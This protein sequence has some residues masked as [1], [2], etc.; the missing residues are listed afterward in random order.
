MRCRRMRMPSMPRD[1]I[2]EAYASPCFFPYQMGGFPFTCVMLAS[3]SSSWFKMATP[4]SLRCANAS[5][6]A[7]KTPSSEPRFSK[8][9]WPMLVITQISGFAVSASL[10]ISPKSDIPISSAAISCSFCMPNIVRGSPISL[11]KFPAV[12][13]TLYFSLNTAAIIS[14][15]LVLPT[16]PVIPMTFISRDFR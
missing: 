14:F 8:W 3:F 7:F 11:L 5:V 16:L 2:S 1:S 12:L 6:F 4:F 10:C 15:V 9:H 13:W